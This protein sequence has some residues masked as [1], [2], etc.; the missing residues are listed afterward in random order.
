MMNYTVVDPTSVLVT[1]LGEVIRQ[2]AAELLSRGQVVN[3]LNRLERN[4]PHLTQE[5]TEKFKVGQI[6]RFL[7]DLLR[8]RVP[9][10]DLERILEAAIEYAGQANDAESLTEHIRSALCRTLSQQ[11]CSHDGRL[12][13]VCLDEELEN[14]IVAWQVQKDPPDR[15]L[16]MRP[17]LTR[18]LATAVSDGV[19][20]LQRQGRS[21]VILCGPRV[22]SAVRRMIAP[23]WPNAAV[24]G[25]NEVESV[26]VQSI[27]TVRIEP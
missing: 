17:E 3:A 1:H 16:T 22:R 26:E 21:P 5:V 27:G 13:C 4:A 7:Q 12:W 24:L 11:Y 9:I 15:G 25:Y 8:E 18:K 6:Q 19:T 20:R 23:T 10:H 2:H 14:A